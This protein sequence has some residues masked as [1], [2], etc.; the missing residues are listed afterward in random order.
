[1][2]KDEER[3]ALTELEERII[4]LAG[5]KG[6]A[7]KRNRSRA[8]GDRR[9]RGPGVQAVAAVRVQLPQAIQRDASPSGKSMQGGAKY[10]THFLSLDC[11][12][13]RVDGYLAGLLVAQAIGTRQ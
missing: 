3:I 10:C 5:E 1:M 4:A 2:K 7:S 9:T 12:F 11:L 13:E 8:E 6:L